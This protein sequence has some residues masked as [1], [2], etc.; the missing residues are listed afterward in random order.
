MGERKKYKLVAA[1]GNPKERVCAFFSTPKGCRSGAQCKFLHPTT[2]NN[3][4]TRCR[5]ATTA[6]PT[7]VV[8]PGNVSS[9]PVP[10]SESSS[11]D[12]DDDGGGGRSER[13]RKTKGRKESGKRSLRDVEREGKSRSVTPSKRKKKQR[14]ELSQ[15]PFAGMEVD[16]S[17][18]SGKKK[19]KMKSKRNKSD[20]D[21][22]EEVVTKVKK[23]DKKSPKSRR[24]SDV[25]D[26][27]VIE[28]KR[29]EKK[30]KKKK[31]VESESDS[32]EEE[33][34]EEEKEEE[35]SVKL[36]KRVKKSKKVKKLDF[37][38]DD[39]NVDDSKV[40]KSGKKTKKVKKVVS[41]SDDDDDDNVKAKD[42]RKRRNKIK[43]RQSDSDDDSDVDKRSRSMTKK[44]KQPDSDSEDSD[45]DG[46]IGR[47]ATRGKKS[48][49]VDSDS[50]NDGSGDDDDPFE[51]KTRGKQSK[52]VNSDSDSDDN[53][54]SD[55]DE[56]PFG[57]K[58]RGKQSKKSRQVDSDTGDDVNDDDDDDG[59]DDNDDDN[60][61]GSSQTDPPTSVVSSVRPNKSEPSTP[62][63]NDTQS[64]DK[65]VPSFRDL[66]LPV[67]P[68]TIGGS[69]HN[70]PTS[71]GS[72]Q[73]IYPKS[74]PDAIKKWLFLVQD[75]QKQDN[76]R[77]GYDFSK[78]K[79]KNPSK[80]F[81]ARPYGPWCASNPQA[82]AIDCEMCMTRD[83]AT[84]AVDPM[85]LCR[86]SVVNADK[87][88]EVLLDT[89][90]KPPHPVVDYRSHITDI[91]EAALRDVA[92]TMEHAQAFM[93]HLCSEET[94]IIGHSVSGDL[95]SLFMEHTCV[96]DTAMLY[97]V[98]GAPP[99]VCPSLKDC[100][101]GVYK[102]TMPELHDSVNDAQVSLAIAVAYRD[103]GGEKDDYN[104]VTNAT[105]EGDCLYVHAHKDMV[106]DVHM[107]HMFRTC[108]FVK[109]LE[110]VDKKL[111]DD[112]RHMRCFVKFKS[113]AHAELALKSLPGE[114]TIDDRN[115][116]SK[117]VIVG[118]KGH[119]FVRSTVTYGQS[120]KDK[121]TDNTSSNNITPSKNHTPSKNLTPSKNNTYSN[122]NNTPTT[123]NIPTKND[124][125]CL[126]VHRLPEM[127]SEEHISQMFQAH[128]EIKP[129]KVHSITQTTSMSGNVTRKC[130]VAFSSPA[131]AQRAFDSLD[132]HP[133]PDKSRRLE[134]RVVLK[135]G[136]HIKVRTNYFG[137]E[138]AT[139]ITSPATTLP[140]PTTGSSRRSD[141]CLFV[142]RLPKMVK[143]GHLVKMFE[144]HTGIKPVEVQPIEFSDKTWRAFGKCFV[145]FSSRDEAKAAFE[146]LEEDATTDK[147]GRLQK[148][149]PLKN[150]DYIL[151]R[152]TWY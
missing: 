91:T 3:T 132:G 142:H 1:G 16:Y 4:T 43:Q 21:D 14:R 148:R 50:D 130:Y 119:V 92:F 19:A 37:D 108:A 64:K 71:T 73:P 150:K 31:R 137:D 125:K 47:E 25:V 60:D 67:A 128:T 45:S 123:H 106:T 20:N 6:S 56:D 34:E 22:E 146:A 39:D 133:T 77:S 86:L 52:Q 107:T 135:N 29:R 13:R 51:N 82:I 76:F 63:Q 122:S 83:P 70:E 102:K 33:E 74:N 145:T 17:N 114:L 49:R 10:S 24:K 152:T 138:V 61:S 36:K 59:N 41:D 30:M 46:G 140:P 18:S 115:R 87:P 35:N 8:V 62:V 5:R 65:S 111:C 113:K 12:D 81:T 105:S 89:L 121:S 129:V 136:D 124:T 118:N 95:A 53:D 90:V 116:S 85:A 101:M 127:V 9:S 7:N 54:V 32:E 40:T 93:K 149:V 99:A 117:K 27:D 79:L 66:A 55:G 94:V 120:D 44:V 26:E 98:K 104:V 72:F 15:S 84:G 88:T 11:S 2:S 141:N 96:V 112:R 144:F 131:E 69:H 134:K 139:T 147:S 103:N 28:D 100:Y 143:D 68:F 42:R 75:T 110:I 58:M 80:W 23:R 78:R 126:F 48:K 97:R 38:S 151:V 57:N 109:P